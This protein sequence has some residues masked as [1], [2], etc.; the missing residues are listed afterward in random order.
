MDAVG[1]VGAP[2]SAAACGLLA[3]RHEPSRLPV[4]PRSRNMSRASRVREPGADFLGALASGCSVHL[5][6]AEVARADVHRDSRACT[7]D[8]RARGIGVAICCRV[9]STRECQSSP[10][11]PRCC[12]PS[13]VEQTPLVH[14]V[15]QRRVQGR[16]GPLHAH[17]VRPRRNPGPVLARSARARGLLRT[18]IAGNHTDTIG[19]GWRQRRDEATEGRTPLHHGAIR[20]Y[21]RTQR[22]SLTR[23]RGTPPGAGCGRRGRSADAGHIGRW[24]GARSPK[25]SRARSR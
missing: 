25:A 7:I 9:P 14:Q 10:A 22:T 21:G 11:V 15:H 19:R 18:A 23:R 8:E 1:A 24:L 13:L 3:V 4:D 6:R 20:E 17:Q 5:G 16:R 2:P 12:D